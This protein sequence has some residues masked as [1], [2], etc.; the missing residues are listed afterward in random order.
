MKIHHRDTEN[1]EKISP[2]RHKGHE[3]LNENTRVASIVFL[4]P[5]IAFEISGVSLSRQDYGVKQQVGLEVC[6]I[7]NG[8]SPILASF[9]SLW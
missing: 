8:L 7:R 4:V 3:V 6:K 1:T 2:Q 9:V 5:L